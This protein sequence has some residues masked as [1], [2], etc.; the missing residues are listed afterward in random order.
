MKKALLLVAIALLSGSTGAS[1]INSTI[2]QTCPEDYESVISMPGKSVGYGNPGPPGFYSHDLCVQGIIDSRVASSCTKNAAFYLSEN[3]SED[4]HLS[5]Y[6]SYKVPVCTGRMVTRVRS[7]CPSGENALMSVSGQTNAHV[8]EPGF[9]DQ[10]VCGFFAPPQNVT[11]ELEFNLTSSDSVYIDDTQVGEEDIRLAEYPYIVSEG[12]GAVAG[13]V[14]PNMIRAERKLGNENRLV[15][16]REEGSFYVPFT[17]GGHDRIEDDQSSM[18]S[19]SFET[20][21]EPSFGFFTPEEATIRT[22]LDTGLD[23]NSGLE[24]GQGSHTL[25]ITKTGENTISIEER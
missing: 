1:V 5:Q 23:I 25:E 20:M 13:I 12:G 10:Q 14:A 3:A 15:M 6:S 22:A 4:A 21:L 24:L 11:L 17:R 16:E 18:L 9:Y 19:G 8:A 2:Q 7:S